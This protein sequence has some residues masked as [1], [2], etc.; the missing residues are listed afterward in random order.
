MF[1][2]HMGFPHGSTVKNP[3]NAGD[4]GLIPGLGRSLEKGMATH[5]SILAWG[6]SWTEEPG[7]L[8]SMGSQTG[9]H[10]WSDL[11]HSTFYCNTHKHTWLN[12]E[13]K[14]LIP[15][16]PIWGRGGGRKKKGSKTLFLAILKNPRR[17]RPPVKSPHIPG[18]Q[19]CSQG[20]GS[21]VILHT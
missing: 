6:I 11:A 16:L 18:H 19:A 12:N 2:F 4:V 21:A 7:G 3:A 20:L 1:G 9:G 8:Q 17:P 5:S 14:V 15:T 10:N 13:I